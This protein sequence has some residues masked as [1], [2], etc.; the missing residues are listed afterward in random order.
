MQQSAVSKHGLSAKEVLRL[1]RYPLTS[2]SGFKIADG[3]LRIVGFALAP[4]GDTEIVSFQLNDGI[5]FTATY[6]LDSPIANDIYW[7]WPNAKKSSFHVDIDLARTNSPG[8]TYDLTIVFDAEDSPL[9]HIKNGYFIPKDLGAYENFPAAENLRRVQGFDTIQQVAPKAFSHYRRL[10]ALAEHYAI[11]LSSSRILDW[12]CGHGRVIRYFRELGT[13]T[14]LFGSDI[15]PDNIAWAQQNL[16]GIDFSVGPLMPPTRF[17]DAMFDLVFGISVMTHLTRKVQ[18]AWLAEIRRILRP[19]G[20]ALLTFAGDTSVAY[21]SRF[22]QPDWLKIY[23]ETGSGPDLPSKDLVGQIDDPSYYKNVN[24]SAREVRSI[25]TPYFDVIDVLE[26]MFG[27][28]DLA[29]LQRCS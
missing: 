10:R 18:L 3:V 11:D 6:P 8:E 29:V 13:S 14:N 2:L 15:D 24:I 21:S 27:H 16:P 23:N 26:C 4:N 7:Y 28:Q 17:G 22:L 5:Y 19:G 12:G 20:L 1:H 9:A 25:C